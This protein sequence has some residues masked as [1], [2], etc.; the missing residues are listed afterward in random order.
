[1]YI[2]FS[3][4][5]IFCI[6]SYC[7]V[8]EKV[9]LEKILF[10]F[11]HGCTHIPT[12]PNGLPQPYPKTSPTFLRTPTLLFFIIL[13]NN[14]PLPHELV[15]WS[16]S[17]KPL[18]QSFVEDGKILQSPTFR[19]SLHEITQS[20]ICSLFSKAHPCQKKSLWILSILKLTHLS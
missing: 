20:I 9:F 4:S 6:Y 8:S 19:F 2:F 5:Y 7:K 14:H 17:W 18:Y 13:P 12:F 15:L 3:F 10:K 1:M 11:L 16:K